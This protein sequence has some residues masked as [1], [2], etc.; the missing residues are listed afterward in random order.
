MSDWLDLQLSH[1]LA[2]VEAP[3]ALWDRIQNAGRM[4]SAG[5]I[6]NADRIQSAPRPARWRV[7]RLAFNG[8]WFSVARFNVARFNGAWP[9]AAILTLMAAAGT[10]WLVARGEEPALDLRQLAI[11]QVRHAE[12]V[13]L[14]SSDPAQISAWM[15][16]AGLDVTLPS[17]TAATVRLVGA[18]V[19]EKRGARNGG[20]QY[21]GSI[22]YIGEIQYTVG[23]DRATLL[24][25]RAGSGPLSV[26]DGDHR[27]MAWRS[28]GQSYA[29]A[30]SS[31]ERPDAAC[32]LCHASL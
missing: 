26:T 1:H 12:P 17:E 6:Q 18:R 11:E 22:Q 23:P 21:I 29:V 32:L 8:A 9:L 20:I 30:S 2:A 15:R 10:L 5:R 27:H 3:E 31:S 4:Q 7:P 28:R 14:R 16:R 25:A 19:I 24:V 13:E